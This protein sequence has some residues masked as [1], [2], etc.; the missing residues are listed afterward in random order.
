MAEIVG[1]L[2]SFC[3]HRQCAR[4][5]IEIGA[6]KSTETAMMVKRNSIVCSCHAAVLRPNQSNHAQER[7][8]NEYTH[9]HMSHKGI[10]RIIERNEL[11]DKKKAY[12][13]EDEQCADDTKKTNP[14]TR[15][16]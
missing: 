12:T 16:F 5:N 14:Y 9:K 13:P 7:R 1:K 11:V 4:K 15:I 3:V 6:E 8:N 2:F 10:R